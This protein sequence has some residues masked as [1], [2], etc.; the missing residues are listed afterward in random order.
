MAAVVALLATAAGGLYQRDYGEADCNYQPCRTFHE[1][2]W[3]WAWRT[4]LPSER[5]QDDISWGY[6]Q[7]GYAPWVFAFTTFVWFAAAVLLVL[8]GAMLVSSLRLIGRPHD[9]KGKPAERPP[10]QRLL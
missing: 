1:Y 10:G 5:I 7:E 4:D 2:G 3:P 6:N 9:R 8:A